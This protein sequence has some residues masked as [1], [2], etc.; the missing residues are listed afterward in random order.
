MWQVGSKIEP[1]KH[2]INPY[3]ILIWKKDELMMILILAEGYLN[4]KN[5]PVTTVSEAIFKLIA[6]Y[7][8]INLNY[9]APYGVLELIDR[10]CFVN[11]NSSGNQAKKKGKKE[12]STFA[13]KKFLNVFDKFRE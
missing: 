6:V 3:G 7:Y 5:I 13:M 11:K 9:P 2:G 12:D 8:V 4:Y 1:P 10:F